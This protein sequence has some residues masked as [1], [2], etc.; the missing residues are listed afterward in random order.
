MT[1]RRELAYAAI[2]SERDYQQR[3][4]GPDELEHELAAFVLYMSVYLA[5][6][7]KLATSASTIDAL[8]PIRKVAGLAVACMEKHGAPKRI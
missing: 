8:E 3:K 7:Q 5:E 1:E 2:N 4:W 6:A